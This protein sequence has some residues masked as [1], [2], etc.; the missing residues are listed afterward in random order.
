MVGAGLAGGKMGFEKKF[1][2]NAKTVLGASLRPEA[3]KF[4]AGFS[5]TLA[6]TGGGEYYRVYVMNG[7]KAC[8][9]RVGV[10]TTKENTA[11]YVSRVQRCIFT[12]EKSEAA[13]RMGILPS[14][15]AHPPP[16]TQL[17]K[18]LSGSP[19]I[20]LDTMEI[21]LFSNE[22]SLSLKR[23]PPPYKDPWG[24][25]GPVGSPMY[26]P[27]PSDNPTFGFTDPRG[28]TYGVK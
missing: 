16:L 26:H 9:P 27:P 19:E 5:E 1:R 22:K 28:V 10:H 20:F 18:E 25:K 14:Y 11:M 23:H 21:I 8:H 2:L 13:M 15:M 3:R 6:K 4:F 24:I 12:N 7:D 17:D